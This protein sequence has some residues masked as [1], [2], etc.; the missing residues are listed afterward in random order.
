MI[1]IAFPIYDAGWAGGLN[2][3]KNLLFAI[4]R[5]KQRRIEPCVIAGYTTDP[6]LLSLYEPYAQIIQ[7]RIFDEKSFSWFCHVLQGR[8][9]GADTQLDHLLHKHQISIFSHYLVGVKRKAFYRTIGWIPDFQHLHLPEMFTAVELARRNLSYANIAARSDV[10]VLS[11]LDACN[12]FRRFAPAHANKARILH[13]VAQPD[14]RSSQEV[15]RDTIEKKFDFH[16]KFFYLPNQFWKHKN[17]RIVFEAVKLLKQQGRQVTILCSGHMN[18]SRNHGHIVQ[19]AGF[20][21]QNNLGEQIRFLGMIDFCDLTWLIRNCVAVVNPSLF[22]GW[23]TT[24]E[25]AKSIGKGMILSDLPVH[26]EQNPLRSVFFDPRDPDQLAE[27][28]W[29]VWNGS[30]G[31]PDVELEAL[32]AADLGGRTQEF[33]QTYQDIVLELTGGIER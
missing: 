2:Y 10:V 22:E 6:A 13:F 15:N 1:R 33:A 21:K 24:V 18:D 32:A 26:R 9:H 23:S 20:V 25:E 3:I 17:H 7:T 19:L 30:E 16:G 11:S 8:L 29:E 5:L 12:D 14:M 4:S 31:G 27:V 28:L